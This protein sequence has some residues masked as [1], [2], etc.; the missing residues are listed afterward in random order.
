VLRNAHGL[1][2][3][4]EIPDHDGKGAVDASL[5]F[6]AADGAAGED[7][8]RVSFSTLRGRL[9]PNQELTKRVPRDKNPQPST[10]NPKP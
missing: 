7:D 1:L 3:L 9:H 10:L 2:L 8:F 4:L 6:T 5:F